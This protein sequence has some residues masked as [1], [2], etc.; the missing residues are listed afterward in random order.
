MR[1]ESLVEHP[2]VQENGYRV[3]A[4]DDGRPCQ[5]DLSAL[6]TMLLDCSPGQGAALFHGTLAHGLCALAL[7][8]LHRLG[9]RAIVLSGGCVMNRVFTE[10]LCAAF[11][12]HGIAVHLPVRLPPNDGGLSLGQ[13]YAHALGLFAQRD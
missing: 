2:I 11:S 7:P 6:W 13:V 4:F 10:S 8:V 3:L 1:L 5:L 12:R 9:L